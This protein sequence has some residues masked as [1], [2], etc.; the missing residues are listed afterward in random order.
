MCC[1]ARTSNQASERRGKPQSNKGEVAASRDTPQAARQASYTK[2]Q[3][4][5]QIAIPKIES[6]R[7]SRE[8]IDAE[9]TPTSAGPIRSPGKIQ[10]AGQRV[11]ARDAEVPGRRCDRPES[12]AYITAQQP[13]APDL[14]TT[15]P[16]GGLGPT[17]LPSL[18][19]RGDRCTATRAERVLLATEASGGDFEPAGAVEGSLGGVAVAA[20]GSRLL[21]DPL[22]TAATAA[23]TASAGARPPWWPVTAIDGASSVTTVEPT[24]A[25]SG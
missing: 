12:R 4:W 17:A 14:T 1:C 9:S 6:A 23:A 11:V 10:V 22:S 5:A 8:A 19:G 15:L 2:R 25:G 18:P 16:S 24:A 13:L 21:L 7:P 3:E 20:P